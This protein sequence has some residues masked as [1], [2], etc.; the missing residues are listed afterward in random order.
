MTHKATLGADLDLD[1]HR[2]LFFDFCADSIRW[3][4][5]RNLEPQRSLGKAM[6]RIFACLPILVLL[7]GPGLAG[8]NK[9]KARVELKQGNAFYKDESYREAL[10]QFQ[11]GLEL[12][13]AATFAWRSVGL[14]AMAIY[15]PGVETPE[16]KEYA[17]IAVDAFKKYLAAYPNDDRV[18]EYLVTTLISAAR[19]EEALLRLKQEAQTNPNK[20]G[21][22][23]AIITTL[24]K[25]G[26]L[27]E[28]Y[29]WAD[30]K[31]AK[32]STL[33]YSIAV[34]CWSKSYNDPTIDSVTRG[35]VVDTGLKAS[36]KAVTLKPDY[37]EAMAYYNLLYREKAKLE[38][39]PVIAAEWTAK[40][41]EWTKKAIAVRD[42]QKAR[43]AA[44]KK[45]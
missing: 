43:D 9:F 38:L 12:D 21:V 44:Q 23:Q 24:A 16:N 6:R 4:N 26:R 17:Q 42:A 37:F 36:E 40:A 45:T 14:S 29:S 35:Q 33:Y 7:L 8:C 31:G 28:A 32:D 34:A 5:P 39:D 11:K 25:A 18:E 30:S 15:R 19:Y 10:G 13:P 22:Q 27:E 2:R 41:E 3:L 20:A 1:G